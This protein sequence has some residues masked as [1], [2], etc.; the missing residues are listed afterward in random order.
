MSMQSGVEVRVPFLDKELINYASS[1]P[2]RYKIYNNQNKWI[3]KKIMEKYFPND[4]VYRSKV[5][6]G[7][8]LRKWIRND[9]DNWINEILSYENINKR[10]IF[11]PEAVHNLI[12]ANK[13]GLIDASFTI[14]SIICIELWFTNFFNTKF[15]K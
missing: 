8:P 10:G 7:M 6:F 3:L 5:G 1:I 11:N 4:I 14:F 15:K 2:S 13:N 12:K 9:L